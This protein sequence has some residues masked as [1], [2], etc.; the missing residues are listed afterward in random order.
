MESLPLE[1]YREIAF[2][3]D[4]E[5]ISSFILAFRCHQTQKSDNQI[6]KRRR[7][8]LPWYQE[9]ATVF[10]SC[11]SNKMLQID[12]DT[13]NDVELFGLNDKLSVS[14]NVCDTPLLMSRAKSLINEISVSSTPPF[15]CLWEFGAPERLKRL[16]L[17][18]IHLGREFALPQHLQELRVTNCEIRCQLSNS[19]IKVTA[20]ASALTPLPSSLRFLVAEA[21]PITFRSCPSNLNHLQLQ[22]AVCDRR[23]IQ[24]IIL[25][26]RHHLQC[27]EIDGWSLSPLSTN[28]TDFHSL[29]PTNMS[30]PVNC[31]LQNL[32][33]NLSALIG[34]SSSNRHELDLSMTNDSLM[35]LALRSITNLTIFVDVSNIQIIGVSPNLSALRTSPTVAAITYSLE[36]AHSKLRRC[37]I[38]EADQVDLDCKQLCHLEL[39]GCK[40]VSEATWSTYRSIMLSCVGKIRGRLRIGYVTSLCD[41][42]YNT[43]VFVYNGKIHSDA[44]QTNYYGSITNCSFSARNVR[45]TCGTI[46]NSRITNCENLEL[47]SFS[48]P[49]NSEP[50]VCDIFPSTLKKLSYTELNP[51]NHILPNSFVHLDALKELTLRQTK[52]PPRMNIPALVSKLQLELVSMTMLRLS[53]NRI[54]R[55]NLLSCNIQWILYQNLQLSHLR[56]IIAKRGQV[57]IDRRTFPSSCTVVKDERII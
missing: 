25:R 39:W 13:L 24:D 40:E 37:V 27:F 33:I 1:I 30:F 26:N 31:R 54:R 14:I 42:H 28:F 16:I 3:L 9:A 12:A 29:L 55:I 10:Q 5:S 38:E 53:P 11:L 15:K 45:I 8:Q 19:I 6:R 20:T 4:D 34:S 23:I 46:M 52:L 41:V 50:K 22:S 2:Y 18:N 57:N 17:T 48:E 32:S 51:W 43:D 35:A 36:L 47:E 7:Y 56:W 49:G 44:G 21:T